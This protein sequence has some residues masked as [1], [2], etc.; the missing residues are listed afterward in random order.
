MQLTTE[1]KTTLNLGCNSLVIIELL[2]ALPSDM[3]PEHYQP[4]LD[5]ILGLFEKGLERQG[6][7]PEHVSELIFYAHDPLRRTVKAA[8]PWRIDHTPEE[9]GRYNRYIDQGVEAVIGKLER[10]LELYDAR[11]KIPNPGI[12]V[13][14]V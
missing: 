11:I 14:I 1:L 13:N 7:D 5:R 9:N 8:P 2:N 12:V 10:K 3:P 6:V 4:R